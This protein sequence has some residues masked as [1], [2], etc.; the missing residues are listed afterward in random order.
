MKKPNPPD[1]LE[2]IED[3]SDFE[4]LF[5][6]FSSGESSSDSEGEDDDNDLDSESSDDVA[7][8]TDWTSRGKARSPFTFRAD[9]GVKFTVEDKEN[10]LEYFEKYFDDELIE[11]LVTE[12][13]RFANDYLDENLETLSPKARANQWYD[14]SV[15]EMKVFIGLLILQ[16]IDSKLDNTM[17]FSTRESIASPF[18]RKIISGRRFDLLHK[19][20]HLVDNRTITDGPGRKIA[21]I[22]PFIDLVVKKFQENYVPKKNVSIDESLLGWKGNLSWVQYIPAKRKRFGMKFFELCES[23]TGYI[24]N[25]F[26]YAGTDTPYLEKYMNLPVTSRI[27]FTLM[28]PLLGKGY[29]LYTDNY[30]TSPALADALAEHETDTVGT[31]RVVRKDVPRKVKE[32][33]LKKGEIVAEYRKKS[34]V[35]KWKDKKDVCVLSTIHD[36]SVVKVKSRRGKEVDKPKAVANYNAYMGGVD[37]SDN[38]LVHFS[39]ARNRLKKYYRKVFRH[40]LDMSVLNAFIAYKA[41]GGKVVRREFILRL[42]ERMIAKYA[43]DRPIPTRPHRR[44]VAK[45]SRLI[46]RHFPDHCPPTAKKKDLSGPVLSAGIV[47]RER[48]PHIGVRVVKSACVLYRALESGTQRNKFS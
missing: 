36:G 13:N 15:N 18:F 33:K 35:L 46:G 4:A 42:S 41:L 11:Y 10:P 43:G 44:Q 31:V 32:S 9:S 37:L 28:D 7:L 19:F 1:E 3:D 23:D 6:D 39:T 38:L 14:M 45:P 25:F 22:K 34:M 17:Y 48:T 26:I 40:M 30:Y 27:V 5:L 8:P 16:G 24:W 21:K 2:E 47:I 29:C 12:T 20:L